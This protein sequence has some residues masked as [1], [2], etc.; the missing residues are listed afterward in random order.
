MF[1]ATRWEQ[2]FEQGDEVS[3][4]GYQDNL[5]PA[6][7]GKIARQIEFVQEEDES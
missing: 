6:R 1:V 3:I 4:S 2:L 7:P 5:D